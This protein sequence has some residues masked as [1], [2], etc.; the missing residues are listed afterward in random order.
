MS[1]CLHGEPN[2]YFATNRGGDQ[3]SLE[4]CRHEGHSAAGKSYR[5]LGKNTVITPH[6]AK[7]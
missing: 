3:C 6:K 5:R 7:C 4:D 2:A 1:T